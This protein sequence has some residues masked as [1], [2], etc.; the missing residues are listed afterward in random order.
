MFC[1]YL[2]PDLRCKKY[3]VRIS[4]RD[5]SLCGDIELRDEVLETI[6]KKVLEEIGIEN[7]IP[8]KTKSSKK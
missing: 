1:K 7:E 4:L 2:T 8:K 5:C 3:R 6:I